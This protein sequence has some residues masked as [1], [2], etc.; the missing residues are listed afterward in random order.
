MTFIST[1]I[2]RLTFLAGFLICCSFLPTYAQSAAPTVKLWDGIAV[3]GYVD[4]G[5]Y[6]NFAGPALKWTRKPCSILLGVLPSLKIK[7]DKSEV[8]NA[9]ITPTLGAGATFAFKH[10]VVQVPVYY[11]P[12]SGTVN[13]RWRPGIGIGFKL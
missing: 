10:F 4:K 3:A 9:L 7:K 11:Q 8:K 12:K 6:I 5:A 13:G 2:K 1:Q